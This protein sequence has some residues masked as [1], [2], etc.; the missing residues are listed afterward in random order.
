M[1]NR[2]VLHDDLI[3]DALL[4]ANKLAQA[5]TAGVGRVKRLLNASYSNSLEQQLELEHE[6]QIESGKSEDFREGVPPF[7]KNANRTLPADRT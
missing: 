3:A 7:L 4:L 1:I 6:L 2:V 5:P